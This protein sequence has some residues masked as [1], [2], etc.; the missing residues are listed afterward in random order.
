MGG[1]EQAATALRGAPPHLDVHWADAPSLRFL[2]R[3]AADLGTLPVT[4]LVSIRSGDRHDGSGLLGG[5]AGSTRGLRPKRLSAQAVSAVVTA[6]FPEAAPEFRNA[7]VTASGGNPFHLREILRAA[8]ADGIPATA[9]GAAEVARL[10]PESVLR[11]VLLRL[12]RVPGEGPAL[13][14]AAAIL[15]D[16]AP[17]ARAAELAG[18]DEETAEQAADA[19]A[20]AHILEPGEPL[21]FTHP[22]IGAAIRDDQPA[23]ARSRAHRKAASLLAAD[24]AP[25]DVIASHLIASRPAGDPET[26]GILDRAAENAAARGEYE[27]ARRYL[28]RALAE[29]PPPGQQPTLRLRLAVVEAALGMSGSQDRLVGALDLA[30]DD[31]HRGQVLHQMA[32]LHFARADFAAAA[33]AI[34]QALAHLGPGDPLVPSCAPASWSWPRCGPT[35]PLRPGRCL[36]SRRALTAACRTARLCSARWP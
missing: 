8:R 15:S 12:G 21:R 17:L 22:L 1:D 9:R 6:A 26:A 36:P 3:L 34:R 27:T 13:A 5:L 25:A 31:R 20:R 32:R 30:D 35:W 28:V 11:S 33:G 18:L 24:G 19:L 29:P 23:L 4:V 10:M 7:C 2:I 16:G 14:A